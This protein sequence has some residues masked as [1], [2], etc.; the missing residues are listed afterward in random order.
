MGNEIIHIINPYLF[1]T[2]S[3][4]Y[5][6]ITN[7]TKFNN[8]VFTY[9]TQNLEQ[10]PFQSIYCFDSFDILR[11]SLS[12]IYRIIT[13]GNSG[14]FYSRYLK[15]IRPKILHAHMGYEG[16]RWVRF[17][18]KNNVPLITTFYGLDVSKLGKILYWQKK[19][20]NLFKYGNSFLAEGNYLKK[21][22]I[23]LGCD[24]NKIIVQHLG[25]AFDK[26]ERK[27]YQ[28]H[29]P[30]QK[31]RIIQVSSFREKKGIEYSL[32]AISHLVKR[33]IHVEFVL[34]GGGDTKAD[35]NKLINL[36]N[37][38]NIGEHVKFLGVKSHSDTLD[39]IR[40]SDIFLHPSVTASDGDNEGGAPVGIMEASAI[41]LPVVSTFHADIPEVVLNNKTGLLVNERNSIGLS[42]Q[43]EKLINNYDLRKEMGNKGREH[44]SQN[45]NLMTQIK[46]LEEIYDRIIHEN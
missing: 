29:F 45:Y 27:L 1:Y 30:N 17:A 32:E 12:K 46:K 18:K 28:E 26:Y 34:I 19:Y 4:I 13:N 22:L 3:W 8:S 11:K 31:T 20:K 38:L 41:G 42:Y 33:S 23:E 24:E 35:E 2:G 25:V 43:I 9:S 7:V 21:Q 15:K 5:S 6:Q 14:L 37:K 39:E 36:S 44:I 10:F 16:A 40:D